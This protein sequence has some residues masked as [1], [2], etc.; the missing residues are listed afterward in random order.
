MCGAVRVVLLRTSPSDKGKAVRTSLH[1]RTAIAILLLP[2]LLIYLVFVFIPICQS[3]YYSLHEGIPG[4]G[5]KFSGIKQYQRLFS[6]SILLKS[7]KV[8][9]EYTAIVVA[10]QIGLGLLFALMI[11]YSFRNSA[12]IRTLVFFPIVLPTVAVGQLFVKIYEIQPQYGLLN[13]FLR[14]VG[15]D[16]YI[17]AWI[18]HPSTALIALC[19][20]DIWR[21]IGFYML[22]FY[23]G[24]ISISQE[25][26]DAARIDGA[27]IN[28]I[29]GR[30]ILP[31]LRPVTAMAVI[32]CLNGTLKAFET[33]VALTG[34][35]P[36]YE[37]T[38]TTIYMFDAAFTYGEF[39]Y[40]STI[41]VLI[42]MECVVVTF[43][44]NRLLLRKTS[45]VIW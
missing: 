2:A 41:A 14:L 18:G 23:A 37:T 36:G 39:G 22:L 11:W 17:E 4:L 31:L 9:A 12:L 16:A 29:V 30:I 44:A 33:V 43:L 34:G 5:L 38:L 27:R 35:G 19:V 21:A 32:Y 15:L 24:L 25:L 42:L 20:Q 13:S 7:L 26:I 45:E 10:G 8:T 6:D 40:G 1:N 28:V 3:F